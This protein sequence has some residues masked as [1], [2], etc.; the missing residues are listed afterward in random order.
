[1]ANSSPS[2]SLKEGKVMSKSNS[3][4]SV[5]VVPDSNPNNT[6]ETQTPDATPADPGK[7]AL[8]VGQAWDGYHL[9]AGD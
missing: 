4:E 3:D 7:T 2:I 6:T 1:M 8:D 5:P 9:S